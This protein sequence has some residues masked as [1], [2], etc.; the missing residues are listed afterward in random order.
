MTSQEALKILIK[1]STFIEEE[2]E[3]LISLVDVMEEGDVKALAK[4]LIEQRDR[5]IEA[6]EE[7]VEHLDELLNAELLIDED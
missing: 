1:N 4:A 6:A 5:E 2:K 3:R 7:A